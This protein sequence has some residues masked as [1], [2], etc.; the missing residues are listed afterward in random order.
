[1]IASFKRGVWEAIVI[2]RN[3]SPNYHNVSNSCR[4]MVRL[5]YPD[6]YRTD[7]PIRYDNGTI[8]YD[9]HYVPRDGQRATKAAFK[10]I[11]GLLR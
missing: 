11:D 7:Y 9:T 5:H 6:G 2:D 3:G 1:M 8:G 10:Y 4:Y